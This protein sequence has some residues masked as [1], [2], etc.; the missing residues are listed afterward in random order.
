[1]SFCH[2]IFIKMGLSGGFMVG[3]CGGFIRVG[4][5]IFDLEKECR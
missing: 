3:V 2:G 1:M 4:L 5:R